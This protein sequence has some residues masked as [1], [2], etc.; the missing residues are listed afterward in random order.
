MKRGSIIALALLLGAC[1]T[2]EPVTAPPATSTTTGTVTSASASTPIAK[3]DQIV[4]A[5][6]QAANADAQAHG[7]TIAS[8][9]YGYLITLKQASANAPGIGGVVG[10]VSGFQKLRDVDKVL[11]GA[12]PAFAQACGPLAI[13]IQQAIL[14]GGAIAVSATALW[15]VISGLPAAVG[16]AAGASGILATMG[17]SGVP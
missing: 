11:T 7:D 17:A 1:A 4:L 2:R 6:L 15:P 5:D 16:G 9:C 8:N 14:R 12:N 13:D 3:F 10:V